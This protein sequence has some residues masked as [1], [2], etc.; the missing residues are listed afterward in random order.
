MAGLPEVVGE[1]GNQLKHEACGPA[2]AWRREMMSDPYD[3]VTDY[4]DWVV[5]APYEI[6]ILMSAALDSKADLRE[7]YD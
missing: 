4:L 2:S 7:E 1:V 6:E 3:D 5:P